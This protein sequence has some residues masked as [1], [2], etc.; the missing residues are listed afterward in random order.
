MWRVI[1]V[2]GLLTGCMTAEQRVAQDDGKCRSYGAEPGSSAYV[3]C[4]TQLDAAQTQARAIADAT[5][6]PPGMTLPAPTPS[7]RYSRA[8]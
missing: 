3:Q 1:V 6:M 2:A 8:P 4:R 7:P 5:P